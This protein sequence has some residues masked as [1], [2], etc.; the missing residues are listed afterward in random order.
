MVVCL[1]FEMEKYF[2]CGGQT[3][4]LFAKSGY[5]RHNVFRI[6]SGLKKLIIRIISLRCVSLPLVSFYLAMEV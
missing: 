5:T 4:W 2:Y 1:F 6:D 3:I